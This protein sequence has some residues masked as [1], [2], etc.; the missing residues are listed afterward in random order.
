MRSTCRQ[1]INCPFVAT[2]GNAVG[3]A[4]PSTLRWCI[5][6]PLTKR[7]YLSIGYN[8]PFSFQTKNC[9]TTS[10]EKKKKKILPRRRM[11]LL[12]PPPQ[13]LRRKAAAK[14]ENARPRDCA[15]CGP[16]PPPS[17][18]GFPSAHTCDAISRRVNY[19]QFAKGDDTEKERESGASRR[20]PH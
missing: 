5:D 14:R 3:R 1:S 7:N 19:T 16:Q 4:R 20:E 9:T 11:I 15:G 8:K 17:F 12:S 6:A 10:R 13:L 18:S 2:S